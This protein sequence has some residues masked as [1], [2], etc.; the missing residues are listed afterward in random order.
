MYNH[1]KEFIA[2]PT[3]ANDKEANQSGID[4]IS[5]FLKPIGFTISIEGQSPFHQPVIVA[6]YNNP[7]TSKKVVLYGHYDVEKIKDGEKWNTPP[8]EMTEKNGR[9]YCRG[10]A[11]NKGILLVRLL[12][13]K[14][15]LEAGGEIPNILWIIQGEEEVGGQTPFDIIPEHFNNFGARLYVEETGIYKDG[16][17][18]IFYLP[19]SDTQPRFLNDMNHAIYSG[20]AFLENRS[21]NKFSMCPFLHNI[22]TGSYYIGFGPNDILCNIH[23]GNESL[24]IQNLFNHQI[25]FKNFLNWILKADI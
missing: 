11:D 6:K 16:K 3:I 13:I 21:L 25:V 5:N 8:F 12:A 14:N 20:E 17:P 2:I 1:L 15:I 4:F 22:P 9:Y 19:K 23:K 18:V 7:N 10:I 24:D